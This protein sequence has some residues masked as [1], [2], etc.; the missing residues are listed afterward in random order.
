MAT[1]QRHPGDPILPASRPPCSSTN[2]DRPQNRN[3]TCTKLASAESQETLE[4]LGVN[5]RCAL[6]IWTRERGTGGGGIAP[7]A[8][9]DAEKRFRKTSLNSAT[10]PKK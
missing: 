1:R 4:K 8:S 9:G 10:Q 2:A 5:R 7:K 6:N 3:L